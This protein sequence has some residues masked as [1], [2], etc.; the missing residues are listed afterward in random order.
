MSEPRPEPGTLAPDS[1][2]PAAGPA[3]A[4]LD[5]LARLRAGG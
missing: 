2:L 1:A 4:V 3:Q 5:V